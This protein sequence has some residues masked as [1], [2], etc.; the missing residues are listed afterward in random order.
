M[1]PTLILLLALLL[2]RLR[3]VA[4]MSSLD[5]LPQ[6]R[7]SP[8]HRSQLPFWLTTVAAMLAGHAATAPTATLTLPQ[9]EHEAI[10]VAFALDLSGSMDAS[11]WPHPTPP[12][13]DLSPADLPPSRLQTAQRHLTRL[14][15]DCPGLRTALIA[16]A[17]NAILVAPLADQPDTLRQRLQQLRTDQ[18]QDGTRI[19]VA[20]LAADRALRH[21]P[22]G[23]R[24]IVLL[25]DGVDHTDASATAPLDAARTAAD[26]GVTIHAVAI[27][28]PLALHPVTAPD[29]TIRHE[30]RGEPLDA[31]QLAAI[32]S[33]AG[34][35]LH[36]AQ[37]TDALAHA[38]S[39]IADDLRDRS[40]LRPVRRT[41]SLTGP[42]LLLAALSAAGALWLTASV[43]SRHR[44]LSTSTSSHD[45]P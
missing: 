3:P 8:L 7:P 1:L 4:E 37:D 35:R 25:S 12:P 30:A 36:L 2:W 19:G 5:L 20:L 42:L 11:D 44:P 22:N 13:P 21:A 26:H 34:G 24:V 14:L 38:L 40:A 39:A 31:D 32:A 15:D 18:L 6:R 23:P 16:F 43:P 28:G 29:G 33:A 27:G 17:D 10:N 45:H 9:R 41:V